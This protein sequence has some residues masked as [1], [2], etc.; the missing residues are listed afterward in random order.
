MKKN[1]DIELLP[2]AIDFLEK[3]D[4]KT[5]EKILYNMA[6]ARIHRDPTL[7]KKLDDHIWE[8]RTLYN[9]N[10]FRFFSFWNNTIYKPQLIIATHGIQKK[11]QKTPLKEIQK[12]NAIRKQYFARHEKK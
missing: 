12:A 4:S 10:A 9:G 11:T 6:K 1:F 5:R 7:L 8:F 3:L 2:E